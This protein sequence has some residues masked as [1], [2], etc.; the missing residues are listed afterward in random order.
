MGVL[1]ITPDSFSDG[2]RFFD[3]RK[4]VERA[5]RMADEGADIIDVG[6]ETTKPGS[7][8]VS[9]NEELDRVIPVVEQIARLVRVPISIDTRKSR[10][11]QEALAA[12]ASLVN[13]VSGFRFDPNMA[14]IVAR[15]D[16][17]VIL[18]HS[19]GTPRTMQ[20]APRYKRLMN[21]IW[22]SLR[23]SIET[24]KDASVDPGKIIID[25]GIGFGKTVKHNLEILRRLDELRAMGF[26]I[27]VGTSRKSFIGE[28]LGIESTEE[29]LLGTIAT[30]LI[31]IMKGAGI[32]RVHDVKEM[33]QAARLVDA[34]LERK[35]PENAYS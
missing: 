6:G 27:C 15:Y 7:S 24:A 11:A 10:V 29:R 33:A 8:G 12:G 31:A 32:V 19:I 14:H 17:A 34:V 16:V 22:L 23:D 18:M 35:V 25:P 13:D 30:S 20:N 28:V 3:K 5:V 2:G 4:A 9:V 21:E 1:N 26:P